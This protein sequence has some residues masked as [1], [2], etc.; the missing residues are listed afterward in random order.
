MREPVIG[1]FRES[2]AME[3]ME[4]VEEYANKIPS[5]DCPCYLVVAA[6]PDRFN[7]GR[8]NATMQHYKE[9]PTPLLGILVWYIDKEKGI[10]DLIPELSLPYDIPVNPKDLSTSSSDSFSRISEVGQKMGVI[11]S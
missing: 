1:D 3:C 8:I 9:R 10:C 2:L 6:K 11:L 5:S 4:R 7:Q